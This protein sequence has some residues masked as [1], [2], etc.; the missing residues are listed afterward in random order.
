MK[1]IFNVLLCAALLFLL[2]C[3]SMAPDTEEKYDLPAD[4][5]Y[6][7]YANIN[8]DVA[9]SQ[10]Y[11]DIIEKNKAYRQT[12]ETAAD[13]TKKAV[14]N[15][16]NVLG[17]LDFSKKLYL[18]YIFCPE[19]G[20]FKDSVSA[21]GSWGGCWNGGWNK[22]SDK[23]EQC[24]NDPDA[25]GCG[26]LAYAKPLT[27]ESFFLDSLPKYNGTPRNRVKADSTFKMM[28]MFVPSAENA[29]QAEDYLKSFY[30]SSKKGEITDFGSKFSS[31]LVIQHYFYTGRYDGRPYKYCE[32]G[33]GKEKTQDLADKRGTYY[34][35]GRYT[36][37]LDKNSQKVYVVE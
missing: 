14:D 13:S 35:Y 17:D 15:C 30:S 7:V 36:F 3:S 12:G 29:K 23:D 8:K 25:D 22:I 26:G 19:Q 33:H 21:N 16:K 27:F 18:D 28:C 31:E 5:D 10:I 32:G 4:F 9:M 6:Q 34:D 1:K 37:C 24:D 11:F 2:S 20:W